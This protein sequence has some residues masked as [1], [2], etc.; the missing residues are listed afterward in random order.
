MRQRLLLLAL[1]L[2]LCACAS[3]PPPVA[4]A[5]I[6]PPPIA[7]LTRCPVPADLPDLATARELAEFAA[8]WIQ[9]AACEHGKRRLLVEAWPR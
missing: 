8:G 3:T 4:P 5:E 7:G 9:T 2:S 6:P 1:S